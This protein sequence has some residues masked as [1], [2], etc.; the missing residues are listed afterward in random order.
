MSSMISIAMATFNGQRYLYNQLD[1]LARQTLKPKEVVICDD[2]STDR[3]LEIV[4]DFKRK[5]EFKV[6]VYQNEKRLGYADNFLKAASLC[7]GDWIGFCD[8]DDVWALEKLEI[9]SEYIRKNPS[10]V[11]I[12]HPAEL[13]NYDLTRTGDFAWAS[14]YVVYPRLTMPFFQSGMGCGQVFRAFLV[15]DVPY[16]RRFPASRKTNDVVPHDDWILRL[17]QC[18]G[19]ACYIPEA[20]VKRRRHSE[21][22]TAENKPPASAQPGKGYLKGRLRKR[23]SADVLLYHSKF[24]QN[25]AIALGLLLDA[26]SPA[27]LEELRSAKCYYE[28][29]ATIM[30]ERANLRRS[31]LHRRVAILLRLVL[32]REYWRAGTA[33]GGWRSAGRDALEVFT[34]RR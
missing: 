23:I 8:Q 33:I 10:A 34:W 13:V 22:A 18:I 30:A 21:S 11:L 25:R 4:E 29:S 12:A 32:S 15:K 16:S 27:L 5:S 14:E 9:V 28:R 7:T 26:S 20:L 3:T 1:S 17:S 2:G 6:R 31:K 24:L 19:S